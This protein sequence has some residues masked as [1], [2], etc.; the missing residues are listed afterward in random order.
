MPIF[1]PY[2][3]RLKVNNILKVYKICNHM[4]KIYRKGN[5]EI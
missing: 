4:Y 3:T 2:Y 1:T 5:K